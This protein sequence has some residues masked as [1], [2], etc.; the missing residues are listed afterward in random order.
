MNKFLIYLNIFMILFTSSYALTACARTFEFHYR[1]VDEELQPNVN[2]YM[3]LL[4]KYCSNKNYNTSDRFVIE[5]VD[6]L[7]E[8]NWIGVCYTKY[9]GFHIQLLKPWYQSH[10]AVDQRGLVYHEMSHCLLYREHEDN[11]KHYMNSYYTSL[12]EKLYTEQVTQDMVDQC[13]G[14]KK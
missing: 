7:E 13:Y 5:L 9:N 1:V 8:P 6:Q 2:A 4:D 10:S 11:P 14:D 12:P 3:K